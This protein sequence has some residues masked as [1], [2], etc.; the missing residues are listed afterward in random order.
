MI[1]PHCRCPGC[2]ECDAHRKARE[3][4]EVSSDVLAR[5]VMQR[6]AAYAELYKQKPAIRAVFDSYVWKAV[7]AWVEAQL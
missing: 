3:T 6:D 1:E 2:G 7:D 4:K 5:V